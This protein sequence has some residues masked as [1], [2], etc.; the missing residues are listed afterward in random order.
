MFN[1]DTTKIDI[2]GT[3]DKNIFTHSTVLEPKEFV[4]QRGK[5]FIVLQL[6][7]EEEISIKI[8]EIISDIFKD[9]YYKDPYKNP[10][11]GPKSITNLFENA[12][13]K[14]NKSLGALESEGYVTWDNNIHIAI[15]VIKN[16]EIHLAYTGKTH[17]L[18]LRDE[19]FIELS[20]GDK[21]V[22]KKV[23]AQTV[24]GV[25][26]SDDILIFSTPEL[27]NYISEEKIKRSLLNKG[28]EETE[29]E[30]RSIL[31]A[32][33]SL[34]PISGIIV[35]VKPTTELLQ[36][37]AIINPPIEQKTKKEES[38]S[39]TESTPLPEK[40]AKENKPSEKKPY[41]VGRTIRG[42]F[43]I[44]KNNQPLSTA[45]YTD[46]TPQ[47][48][49]TF[50][51]KAKKA[52]ERFFDTY[53]N[54]KDKG[55]VLGIAA[56]V[57]AFVLV[58]GVTTTYFNNRTK[59]AEA[60]NEEAISF[61][62]E[63]EQEA[64]N[65]I[66]YRDYNTAEILLTE[67]KDRIENDMNE[68]GKDAAETKELLLNIASHFDKINKVNRV[69]S[70]LI[71]PLPG[72]TN[73]PS[74]VGKNGELYITTK[75]AKVF[76]L[77]GG[78]FEEFSKEAS[79]IADIT[80]STFN[81]GKDTIAF[82]TEKGIAEMPLFS[83]TI[84]NNGDE[85]A[86]DD[87]NFVA[88]TI[89][90]DKIYLLD[91]NNN[92]LYRLTRRVDGYDFGKEWID[93][94]NVNVRDGV[95]VAIDSNV[96]IL[97]KDGSI[98]KLNRGLPEEFEL[99]G[100]TDTLSEN[101]QLITNENMENLYILDKDVNVLAAFS[102]TGQLLN[103]YAIELPDTITDFHVDEINQTAYLLTNSEVH[104]IPIQE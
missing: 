32:I 19:K 77:S 73:S 74:L 23:F 54:T 7:L 37:K 44:P 11:Y 75:D 67:A 60:K 88:M 1:T 76:N 42:S 72:G 55:K 18:L 35:N 102:K 47:P 101:T 36:K 97:K 69:S 39:L 27:L 15:C 38:P 98:I 43:E 29:K 81:T 13:N 22:Q 40:P 91:T 95:S 2:S 12:I 26:E 71:A 103:Q 86:R 9:E 70:T 59:A 50:L 82:A 34:D 33:D 21:K 5:S 31:T 48:K 49:V 51:Q 66:I 104:S 8:S 14:V 87:H 83:G 57:V 93:D 20:E 80:F 17:A 56:G 96:Y 4:E 90:Q 85:F 45:G 52:V 100:L 78:A 24:S 62:T 28:V 64:A 94:E 46:P 68:D 65:A 30:I 16:S 89:Y 6:D 53:L 92:Q 58:A 61:A 25:I 41:L 63:K 3:S 10:T 84:S 79:G 99:T